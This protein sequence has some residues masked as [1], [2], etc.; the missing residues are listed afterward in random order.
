[1]PD[2]CQPS[3]DSRSGLGI[4]WEMAFFIVTSGSQRHTY[5]TTRDAGLEMMLEM[6]ELTGVMNVAAVFS[7]WM[8]L[9]GRN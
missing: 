3:D 8:Y 1:M 2:A 4:S 5:K 7:K 6:I 9:S